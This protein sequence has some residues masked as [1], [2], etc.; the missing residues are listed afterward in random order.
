ML[1][2][3]RAE[4]AVGCRE[5]LVAGESPGVAKHLVG[6]SQGWKGQPAWGFWGEA[7]DTQRLLLLP[8]S[9]LTLCGP[10]LTKAALK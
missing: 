8:Y 6:R 1:S 2:E 5:T 10:E 9:T 3:V 4:V 7:G